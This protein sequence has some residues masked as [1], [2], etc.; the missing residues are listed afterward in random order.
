QLKDHLISHFSV[1]L[2]PFN[3]PNCF[4]KL[5]NRQQLH[6]HLKSPCTIQK[7]KRSS[8]ESLNLENNI[9]ESV[10]KT[11]LVNEKTS[12]T[13]MLP[14]EMSTIENSIFTLGRNETLTNAELE[15]RKNQPNNN[16]SRRNSLL[17]DNFFNNFTFNSSNNEISSRRNSSPRHSVMTRSRKTSD[18]IPIQDDSS[19][20]TEPENS[21]LN[22]VPA[23]RPRKN[24]E[25]TAGF[26][27]NDSFFNVFSG[28]RKNSAPFTPENILDVN[29]PLQ[30]SIVDLRNSPEQ[31][32]LADVEQKKFNT[33]ITNLLENFPKKKKIKLKNF[34]NTTMQSLIGSNYR[35]VKNSEDS[36]FQKESY[37]FQNENIQVYPVTVNEK[38]IFEQ[39]VSLELLCNSI[40]DLKLENSKIDPILSSSVGVSHL[41]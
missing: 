14:T 18:A 11:I 9:N 5:R 10:I 7:K 26:H 21:L 29:T 31:Q 38:E 27:I 30:K 20:I 37:E 4:I 28:S 17:L 24:S 3:C 12:S 39:E 40:K 25:S 2:R 15:S 34:G 19:L 22:R 36:E 41:Y 35:E 23:G 8:S 13:E 1:N 32:D 6:G 16:K 33:V